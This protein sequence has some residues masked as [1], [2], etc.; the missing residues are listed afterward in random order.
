MTPRNVVL[1]AC[2]ALLL[3]GCAATQVEYASRVPLKTA[4]PP[5]HGLVVASLG[6][7]S[8]APF[9]WAGISVRPL[10]QGGRNFR[11]D[12]KS[13]P[14]INRIYPRYEPAAR[15]GLDFERNMTEVAVFSTAKE[16]GVVLVAAL[17][18]GDYEIFSYSFRW[19]NFGGGPD[20]YVSIPFSVKPGGATYLGRF[21]ARLTGVTTERGV[22]FDTSRPERAYFEV[23]NAVDADWAQVRAHAPRLAPFTLTRP[24]LPACRRG[25]IFIC[26][27]Q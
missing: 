8:E 6:T 2:A 10:G 4:K 22:L 11:D 1:V 7:Q 25:T 24:V 23:R 18:A 5:A 17:P 20:A 16:R 21:I 14:H 12:L 27:A 26:A 15:P 13:R 19:R 9:D 3:G